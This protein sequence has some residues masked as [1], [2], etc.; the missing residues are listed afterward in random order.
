MLFS[1][2]SHT[3]EV[4]PDP[5]KIPFAY[6]QVI[7]SKV[8]YIEL[9]AQAKQWRIQWQRTRKRK[10]EALDQVKQM[11]V[12]H[13]RE[14]VTFQA[15]IDTLKNQ[16]ADVQHLVFG[17]SSEKKSGSSRKQKKQARSSS[18]PKGQQ[19]GHKGHGRTT[20]TTL[21]VVSE[22]LDLEEHQKHCYGH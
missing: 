9:K 8:D 20:V 1:D 16:L 4:A 3:S 7:L 14:I 2:T 15:Q 19:R 12:E 11:K 22:T 17:R 13:S 21:P 5:V 10:Q 6:A 18:R